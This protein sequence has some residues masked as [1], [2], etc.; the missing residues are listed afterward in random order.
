VLIGIGS[1]QIIAFLGIRESEFA[2]LGRLVP[3]VGV[4]LLILLLFTVFR[5]IVVGLNRLDIANGVNVFAL[6][7]QISTSI[8]F[9]FLGLG[10]WALF[11]GTLTYY[12]VGIALNALVLWRTE[13]LNVGRMSLFDWAKVKALV[14]MG[15]KLVFARILALAM[16]PVVTL[17]LSRTLGTAYVSYFEVG[18]RVVFALRR[19]VAA[20]MQ[21]VLPHVGALE[22]RGL[23]GSKAAKELNKKLFWRILLTGVP[24]GLVLVAL[25]KP[26]FSLWLRDS[27]EPLYA[28]SFSVIAVAYLVNIVVIPFYYS[29]IAWGNTGVILVGHLTNVVALSL[30]LLANWLFQLPFGFYGVILGYCTA[31]VLGSLCIALIYW[32]T[33][34]CRMSPGRANS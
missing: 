11:I 26:M 18:R 17:F 13:R 10:L 6:T 34:S 27:Y 12:A 33:L 29:L 4:L 3:M 15:Y 9:L 32:R 25:A 16:E 7:L 1:N 31:L 5:S 19:F 24:L 8:S 30:A 22:N 2:D 20:G 21:A 14:R 28:W 23:E